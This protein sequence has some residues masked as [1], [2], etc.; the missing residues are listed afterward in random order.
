MYIDHKTR[1]IDFTFVFYCVFLWFIHWIFFVISR[2]LVQ[3]RQRLPVLKRTIWG[4]F[5]LVFFALLSFVLSVPPVRDGRF[6]FYSGRAIP[7]HFH[8]ISPTHKKLWCK[9]R[10]ANKKTPPEWA[11]NFILSVFL[12]SLLCRRRI[13]RKIFCKVIKTSAG[14]FQYLCNTVGRWPA[15]LPVFGPTFTLVKRCCV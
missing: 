14:T 15:R 3:V 9:L 6:L 4:V 1:F 5:S 2:S 7:T 10:C 12:Y 11:V 13:C 8:P